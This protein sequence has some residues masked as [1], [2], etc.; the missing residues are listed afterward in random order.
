MVDT[1]IVEDILGTNNS[2]YIP[3]DLKAQIDSIHAD[4]KSLAQDD[5]MANLHLDT[6]VSE[7]LPALDYIA[8]ISTVDQAIQT[9][10]KDVEL[11][12][13]LIQLYANLAESLDQKIFSTIDALGND[14]GR[15]FDYTGDGGINTV[16]HF[17]W[18]FY[19]GC[20]NLR[21]NNYIK[22]VLTWTGIIRYTSLAIA[23]TGIF[24]V[25]YNKT[26]GHLPLLDVAMTVQFEVITI[27]IILWCA[28]LVYLPQYFYSWTTS[29]IPLCQW[30]RQLFIGAQ[31]S[32]TQ[33]QM[34]TTYQTVSKT[35]RNIRS[36]R[37]ELSQGLQDMIALTQAGK[38]KT[39]YWS[40]IT[41]YELIEAI[42]VGGRLTPKDQNVLVIV[43]GLRNMLP[44]IKNTDFLMMCVPYI[45][46]RFGW[47][48]IATL[49]ATIA[50]N[51]TLF[52]K[53]A[54]F[55]LSILVK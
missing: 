49:A 40:K 32:S 3:D 9:A 13:T 50:V 24:L 20:T 16:W 14:A 48:F 11:V 15:V 30:F 39:Y 29:S 43:L 35:L 2:Q 47:A 34:Y 25:W 12:Q 1:T 53:L 46:N 41:F 23:L 37:E 27:G 19:P 44:L 42:T 5:R 22:Y 33:D 36:V 54:K 4:F 7:N 21:N 55:P 31:T 51:M 18:Y 6:I 52:Q 8:R 10:A 38:F 28:S 17:G 26:K 45:W